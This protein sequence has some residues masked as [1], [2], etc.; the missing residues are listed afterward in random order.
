MLIH[1]RTNARAVLRFYREFSE[2]A[3][4]ELTT[5]VAFITLPDGIQ[6]LALIPCYAGSLEVATKVVQP[7]RE[8]GPPL[9]DRLQSMS[10]CRMQGLLDEAFP[11]GRRNYW[12]SNYLRALSDE[13]IDLLIEHT[14]QVPSPYSAVLIERYTGVVNQ[15]GESETAFPHRRE[16]YNLHIFSAWTSSSE[17]DRNIRWTQDFWHAMQGFSSGSVY[18]NFL[19]AEGHDRVQAAFGANYERLAL[20]K[21][22]YDP[23]NLFRQNQN[24][25]P[26]D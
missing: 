4:D 15:I 14:A 10:F 16:P 22:K 11:E 26:A 17:D 1:A 8:F 7:L 24:I 23:L 5:S 25:R 21:K 6:S 20:L 19:G 2:H 18:V 12:K 9:I 13:A 3:P